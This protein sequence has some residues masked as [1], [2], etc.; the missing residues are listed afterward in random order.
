[1]ELTLLAG[2][3]GV[4]PGTAK[5]NAT[6]KM[7]FRHG[8]LW[9]S[10]MRRSSSSS[11]PNQPIR[12]ARLCK[13]TI[14]QALFFSALALNDEMEWTLLTEIEGVKPG[15]AK[16]KMR[17][18]KLFFRHC[19]CETQTSPAL[20]KETIFEALKKCVFACLL[21]NL[22]TRP[23]CLALARSELRRC[24][25][26]LRDPRPIVV[27]ICLHLKTK[28]WGTLGFKLSDS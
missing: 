12:H 26:N 21:L 13:K 23:R 9:T 20:Q 1:M 28:I 4:K 8:P 5:K 3:E 6:W 7:F 16:K 10:E 18:E 2:I 19:S 24:P 11:V 22:P 15:T 27:E 25:K 17:P 14:F